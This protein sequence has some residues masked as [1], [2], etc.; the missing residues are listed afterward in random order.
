VGRK[1]LVSLCVCVI[2]NS[3]QNV[4]T[5]VREHLLAPR[6]AEQIRHFII[7]YHN[8]NVLSVIFALPLIND[9]Y[10]NKE[11]GKMKLIQN[12]S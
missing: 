10:A 11:V 2:L 4:V 8:K 1:P 6:M 3:I 12:R 7:H 9:F 5:K